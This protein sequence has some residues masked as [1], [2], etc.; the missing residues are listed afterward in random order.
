MRI[1]TVSMYDHIVNKRHKYSLDSM[2]VYSIH[3]LCF[4]RARHTTE[5]VRSLFL[6]PSL[7]TTSVLHVPAHYTSKHCGCVRL[8]FSTSIL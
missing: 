7:V 5:S 8:C 4:H 6:H 2:I 1:S 3:T